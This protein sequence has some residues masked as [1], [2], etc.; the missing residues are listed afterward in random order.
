MDTTQEK[1]KVLI[2]DDDTEFTN[3]FAEKMRAAGL[4]PVVALTGKEAL[5]YL[6]AHPVAFIVL[7][8][9]MPEMDGYTFYHI[10]K[11]DMRKNI[12]TIVLTNMPGTQE[13]DELEV[14]IKS[15]TNLDELAGKIRDRI[16]ESHAN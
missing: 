3:Q 8:F 16:G 11:H 7:D 6:T 15:Q 10:M 4:D 1:K 5:D 9:V 13:A 2:V 12:P 14:F